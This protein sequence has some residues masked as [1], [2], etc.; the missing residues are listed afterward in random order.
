VNVG[1]HVNYKDPIT[2]EIWIS[3]QEY[4]EGAFGFV[5][6][7]VYQRDKNKFQGTASDIQGTENDPF[8]KQC[9]QE[10]RPIDLMFQRNLPGN[11]AFC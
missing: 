2:E 9:A 1:A 6:G 8:I 3:D 10:L 11:P 7:E 5:G 4:R